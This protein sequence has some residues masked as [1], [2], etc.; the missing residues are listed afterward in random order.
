M[1]L[2]LNQMAR[3]M[4][5]EVPGLADSYAVTLLNEAL[6]TIEDQQ[7]WS[8]QLCEGGWLTPGLQ[9][10]GASSTVGVSVGTITATPFTN[11]VVG[12]ATASAAWAAYKAPPFLTSMQIRSPFYSLYNIV[13]YSVN[14]SGFGVFTLDRPWME[15]GGALQPYMI[16]Q[17]YFPVPY[18]DFK[19]FLAIRDTTN[20]CPMDYWTKSQKDLAF[21]DP[22]R[23]EFDDPVYV[24]PY[25]VDNRAGSATLGSMMYELWPHPLNQLPYTFSYMRRGPQLVNPT[26]TPPYP[27]TEDAVLW[28]AKEAA[29]LFKEA[30]KGEKVER[31]SGADFRFLAQMAEAKYQKALKPCKEKDRDMVDLYFNKVRQVYQLNGEPFSNYLGQLNVGRM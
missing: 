17:A 24:V 13:N 12:D 28:L 7:M 4:S 16:Y 23:T 18:P 3:L 29:Y 27:I 1:A 20:S 6:G 2:T 9:F 8:F 14:G 15:P 10:P 22:E 30:Q 5:L 11:T 19:K 31:G 26:D 25:E 21:E